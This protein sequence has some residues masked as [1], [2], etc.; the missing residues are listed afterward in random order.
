MLCALQRDD[1]SLDLVARVFSMRIRSNPLRGPPLMIGT[2]THSL[3]LAWALVQH[4]QCAHSDHS[5]VD[6]SDEEVPTTV[7]VAHSVDH[8][9]HVAVRVASTDVN[10]PTASYWEHE[11]G[12]PLVAGPRPV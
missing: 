8:E 1:Q 12:P 6:L 10:S 5:T 7:A 3:D 9:P 11:T 4:T 2:D